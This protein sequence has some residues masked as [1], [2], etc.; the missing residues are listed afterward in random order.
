MGFKELMVKYKENQKHV[1]YIGRFGY[2]FHD[3][4]VVSHIV[5]GRTVK[6]DVAGAEAVFENGADQGRKTT[7]GRVAAGAI[8]AG[9]VG[10]IVGGM[11]KK[12]K[13]RV[14][15]SIT[16]PDGSVIIEDAPV[17]KER[18]AREFVS[19]IN[20]AARFYST[21]EAATDA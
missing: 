3:K 7:I 11:F 10:A 13:N 8:I 5:S 14:Y 15:V 17:K 1:P 18:E 20:Q 12:N 4:G 16:F 19:K 6:R 9:P 21:S 2:V